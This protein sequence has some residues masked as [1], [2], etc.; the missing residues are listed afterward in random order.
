M[1]QTRHALPPSH[2][3]PR[4]HRTLCHVPM[5]RYATWHI[6]T[7]ASPPIWTMV[8]PTC[9]DGTLSLGS[10]ASQCPLCLHVGAGGACALSPSSPA[11]W[12]LSR[13]RSG[14]WSAYRSPPNPMT[15]RRP[16]QR[17]SAAWCAC[18][19]PLG[20]PA[21]CHLARRLSAADQVPTGTSTHG[22]KYPR[23][24]VP[25]ASFEWMRQRF[26]AV[27]TR[28][29]CSLLKAIA[30]GCAKGVAISLV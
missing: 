7:R 23:V 26:D 28:C 14:V 25:C 11:L 12:W 18:T 1:P 16:E 9:F 3:M 4:T 10:P 13:R 19:L 21:L 24:L 2:T 29:I 15:V 17:H 6:N 30:R 20:V 8:A 22:Y 27:E 5:I